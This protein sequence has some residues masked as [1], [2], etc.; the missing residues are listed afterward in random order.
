MLD[1]AVARSAAWRAHWADGPAF[2]VEIDDEQIVLRR[3]KDN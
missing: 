1:P 2:D 3:R